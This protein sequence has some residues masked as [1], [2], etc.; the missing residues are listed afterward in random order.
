[1]TE[2]LFAS[3]DAKQVVKCV[4]CKKPSK[5]VA[6]RIAFNPLDPIK[7]ECVCETWGCRSRLVS[8]H[9]QAANPMMTLASVFDAIGATVTLDASR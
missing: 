4:D 8:F 9:H 3:I 5:I 7:I 2:H 1:M 6:V